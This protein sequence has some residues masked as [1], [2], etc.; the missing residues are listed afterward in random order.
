MIFSCYL[1]IVVKLFLIEHYVFFVNAVV[2]A[3]NNL[4]CYLRNE[5]DEGSI[6]RIVKRSCAYALWMM[7]S[8]RLLTVVYRHLMKYSE[9]EHRRIRDRPEPVFIT[10]HRR[11]CARIIKNYSPLLQTPGPQFYLLNLTL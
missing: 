1:L 2:Y 5:F 8:P 4:T 11:H 6:D 9:L 10:Y 7:I 3:K